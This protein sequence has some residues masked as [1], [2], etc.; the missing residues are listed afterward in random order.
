MK[1]ITVTGKN[2]F[3]SI[4]KKSSVRLPT[5][6]S[7]HRYR[8]SDESDWNKRIKQRVRKMTDREK[9][10]D[11]PR[12]KPNRFQGHGHHEYFD[13]VITL[14]KNKKVTWLHFPSPPLIKF[15]SLPF[16]LTSPTRYEKNYFYHESIFFKRQNMMFF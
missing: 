7:T 2:L 5:V 10:K 3:K 6:M 16:C 13:P 15:S 1:R 9:M 4:Y 11:H 12:P 8:S 14:C